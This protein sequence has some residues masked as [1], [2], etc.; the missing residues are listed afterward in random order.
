VPDVWCIELLADYRTYREVLG[1][2]TLNSGMVRKAEE[3]RWKGK[4]TVFEGMVVKSMS[5]SAGLTKKKYLQNA[6]RIL[7]ENQV[8][9][10]DFVLP[11]LMEYARE[12][13]GSTVNAK[14]GK[15]GSEPSALAD[16]VSG[17]SA[18]ASELTLVVAK[19]TAKA[20]KSSSG[21]ASSASGAAAA[22]TTKKR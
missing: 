4:S 16:A 9:I 18:C 20:E 6:L 19:P 3:A 5:M 2:L 13:S 1:D 10:V 12:H 21:G 8:P 15:S 22:R 11:M 17:A 7:T 14:S